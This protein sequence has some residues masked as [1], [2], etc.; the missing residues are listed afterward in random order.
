MNY[1]TR[2]FGLVAALLLL[3]PAVGITQL[4]EA[5][6]A[7]PRAEGEGPFDRQNLRG[8]TLID[9]TGAP[10]RGPMDIVI[11]GNRIARIRSVGVCSKSR[12]AIHCSRKAPS[13]STTGVVPTRVV[14]IGRVLI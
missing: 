10:A 2:A 5:P 14:R 12:N 11:E 7:P 8:V 3:T 9:G 4:A 13:Q 1:V 6:K